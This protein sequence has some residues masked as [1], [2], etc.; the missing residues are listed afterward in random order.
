MSPPFVVRRLQPGDAASVRD[1]ASHLDRWFN[2][3]GLDR[4]ACDLMSHSG[5]VAMQGSR[6]LGFILWTPVNAEIAE[7]SWM[8]VSQDLHHRGIGTV[9]LAA[10]VAD[11]AASGFRTL[12]VATVA[13]NVSYEP[14]AETRRF[15]RARGFTD[16]RV[17]ARLWGSGDERYDRLVLRRDLVREMSRA[18]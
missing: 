9:L 15:Y 14:Y 12:E 13:D 4:M 18:T 10:L 6:L 1:L 17:D 7:L 16:F 3:E 11:L 5:F 8:G 2:A